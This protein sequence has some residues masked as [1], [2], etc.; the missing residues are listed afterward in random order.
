MVIDRA[1]AEE[2]GARTLFTI[3]RP[4]LQRLVDGRTLG[5]ALRP[6]GAIVASFRA[7]S[8]DDGGGEPRLLFDVE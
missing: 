7:T 5:L 4:V 8:E 6:L 2:P 1:V 3:S